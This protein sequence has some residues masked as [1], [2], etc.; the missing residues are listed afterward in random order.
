MYLLRT[1]NW[2][3]KLMPP[4]LWQM[5]PYEGKVYI[6]FDDG[7]HPLATP[8]AL[9]QLAKFNAKGSF[10]CVGKNVVEYPN[11]YEQII[12]E[13]HAVGNH[14]HQHKKGSAVKT[15]EYLAD[16]AQAAKFIN[17]KL[18]RPPYGRIKRL[19][20]KALEQQGYSIIMYSLLSADFDKEITPERCLQN[21]VFNLKPGDILV[22]HDSEKAWDRMSYALPRVL[23][24]CR[25]Q[26]WECAAL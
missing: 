1:P 8:F 13:G 3:R 6:T 9:E 10:F 5:P 26:K 19:Q 17:S 14:T 16:I 18:F 20:A 12:T 11:V 22:F 2:L 24:H 21:V 7:P 15:D 4:A 25:K 23:E